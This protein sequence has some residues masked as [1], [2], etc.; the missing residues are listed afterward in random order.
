[1][2]RQENKSGAGRHQDW[3]QSIEYG[4]SVSGAG[5]DIDELDS[6]A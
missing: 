2:N 1:M 4:T 6:E 5:E 3:M